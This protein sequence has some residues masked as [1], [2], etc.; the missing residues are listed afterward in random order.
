MKI[1][2]SGSYTVILNLT[3]DKEMDKA[4]TMD[5]KDIESSLI[6]WIEDAL[7]AA[8]DDFEDYNGWALDSSVVG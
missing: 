3:R 2:V 1:K 6:S 8:V 5:Q 4:D 7:E